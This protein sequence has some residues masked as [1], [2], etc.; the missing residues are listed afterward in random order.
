MTTLQCTHRDHLIQA[1]VMEHPGI[2][3]PWAGGCRIT[4]PNG[5]VT[6]RL[7]LPMQQAFLDELDKAQ[8]ASIAHGKWLVDQH[9][10]NGLS[11][12]DSAPQHRSAA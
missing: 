5:Q 12:M 3:T 2:P 9:L 8:H 7:P 11:L 10:D 6:R 1:E 4:L